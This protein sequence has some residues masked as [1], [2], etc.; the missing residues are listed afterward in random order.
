MIQLKRR[1][2]L[3]NEHKLLFKQQQIIIIN[4]K[5]HL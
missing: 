3:N 4:Y 5:L 1:G 2:I